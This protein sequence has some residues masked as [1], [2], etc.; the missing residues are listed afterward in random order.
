MINTDQFARNGFYYMLAL[1]HG[2]SFLKMLN[3]AHPE[4]VSAVEILQTKKEMIK[5][6]APDISGILLD[7]DH[8]LAAY[9]EL[10]GEGVAMSSLMLRLT[11][12]SYI[13]K[14]GEYINEVYYKAKELKI[15]GAEAVK[16]LFNF[17][18]YASVADLQIETA[19][20][21]MR[22]AHENGLP[23][24][25][26]P[27]TYDVPE[28]AGKDKGTL[29]LES[30]QMLKDHG[31]AP[32]LWKV[33]YP[34]SKLYCEQLHHLAEGVPWILLT[35]GTKFDEFA[36]SLEVAVEAGCQGFLA[37]RALWQELGGLKGDG[38]ERFM[39]KTLPE[40]LKKIK[41]IAS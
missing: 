32:D 1:D 14:E 29:I 17:N 20:R 27:V 38:R 11:K 2:G 4:E 25:L 41:E 19:R 31:V 7:S 10:K 30:I 5:V 18:P 26:E 15:A 28:S 24:L 3:P 16:L 8:G 36:A 37:G 34:G 13:E 39:N 9:N 23:F 40:R 6:L 35:R 12:Q 33:E 22:D 21:A